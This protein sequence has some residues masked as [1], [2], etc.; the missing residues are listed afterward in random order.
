MTKARVKPATRAPKKKPA[1]R[2]AAEKP[3]P[4]EAAAEKPRPR[5]AAAVKPAARKAAAVK[6]PA[7]PAAVKPPAPPTAVKP[8]APPTAAAKPPATPPAKKPAKAKPAVAPVVVGPRR[9][10]FIDVE[11]TSSDA[12]LSRVLD[13]LKLDLTGGAT[14]VTAVGNWRVV[15]QQLGRSLAQRGANLLHS[16]PAARVSDWSDLWIAVQVGIWLGRS[17]PGDTLEIVSHDRAFDAGGDA[18]AR[19]GVVFRR[20]TYHAPGAGT[21]VAP[22]AR[23]ED[24]LEGRRG[25]RRSRVSCTR[26][27][28]RTSM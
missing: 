18:A 2:K 6:P 22:P 1:A 25:R 19:L 5:E 3:R 9:A 13:E 8:P 16:A 26:P 15:G 24:G 12:A 20:I 28:A 23:A 27:F 10:V 21:A 7:P 11:N 14:E 17:R 4:R